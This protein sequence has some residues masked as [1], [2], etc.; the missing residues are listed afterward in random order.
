MT[1]R[2]DGLRAGAAQAAPVAG[3][4][5][6]AVR[7]WAPVAGWAAFT[8]LCSSLPGSALPSAPTGTDKVV[9]VALYA[10][11]GL[12]LA[13]AVRASSAPRRGVRW[14]DALLVVAACTLFGAGDEWHQDYISGRS[15]DRA[16]LAADCIGACLGF[17][18]ATAKR[19]R[20]EHT[21]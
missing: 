6:G 21:S 14:S 7:R 12:L 15:S 20:R 4:D 18:L 2:D 5:S 19:S 3:R 13:R 11:L 1:A 8:L 16:D 17:V 9:H 10:V